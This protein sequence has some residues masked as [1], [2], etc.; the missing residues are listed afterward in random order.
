MV[1]CQA[2]TLDTSVRIRYSQVGEDCMGK[3]EPKKLTAEQIRMIEM[4]TSR[5]DRVEVVPVKD[6]LK[7]LRTRRE[8]VKASTAEITG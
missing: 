8:E 4:V 7:L 1:I 2:K 5:G 3:E 6:G